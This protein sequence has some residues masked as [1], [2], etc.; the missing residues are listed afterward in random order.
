MAR[1]KAEVKAFLDSGVGKIPY[2]PKP[3]EDLSGQCVTEIK[4]LLDFLGVP[5]PYSAR[6]NAKDVADTLLRQGIAENGKG[7]LTIVVNKDMGYIGGVHYGHIWIDLKDEANYESNGAKALHCTKNTRPI[8]QGQQ[9]VNL[10]KW[11]TEGNMT[12]EL[13]A[14]IAKWGRL[15]GFNSVAK[16]SASQ[17]DDIKR[18]MA[19]PMYA[20]YLLESLYKGEWQV[21]AWKAN[22]FDKAVKE[23]YEKGKVEG[24]GSGGN[25]P[26][27]T[28][29]KVDK[30]NVIEVK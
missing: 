10:D 23:S 17:E 19:D 14:L 6:G 18:I 2:H 3:Y 12:Q 22:N 15:L 9:F 26:A 27:G 7:W 11:I 13:A 20:A 24:A 5:A 30:A 1:T 4:I 16:M 29:L 28:Y 21:P 8:Q 25:V